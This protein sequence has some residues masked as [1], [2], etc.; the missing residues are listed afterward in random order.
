[1][2]PP[3]SSMIPAI[4]LWVYGV[5]FM[6]NG[7]FSLGKADPKGTGVVSMAGGA[8]NTVFA[9]ILAGA[10]LIG[11]YMGALAEPVAMV[12]LVT[13]LLIFHFG[14]LCWSVGPALTWGL[15][16]KAAVTS[17]FFIAPFLVVYCPFFI[18]HG[19]YWFAVNVCAWAV[20]VSLFGLVVHGKLN[21]K[22]AGWVWIIESVGT[23]FVPATILF[24]GGTLP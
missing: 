15:D 10:C 24:L 6:V 11:F 1:M 5:V 4:A 20:V 12:G 21:P 18:S 14:I 23:C 2:L 7:F 8:I 3:V 19:M 9:F 13:A 16:L 22:I 17:L